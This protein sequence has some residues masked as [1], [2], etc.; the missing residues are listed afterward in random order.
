MPEGDE[1]MQFIT[2]LGLGFLLGARH[3]L[4]PDHVAAV[5][6]IVSERPD[7][8]ASG[9]VG[10]CWGFGHTVILLLVGVAII[11]L[12]ITIPE[13]VAQALELGV[14]LMLIALGGSLAVTLIRERWHLHPHRHASGTHLHL[15]THRSGQDHLHGHSLLRRRSVKPFL[16]GMVHGLAGSAALTLMLLSTVRTLWEGVL[17]ILVFGFGSILGMMVLGV[18]ISIP[19]VLSASYLPRARVA[20][21]GLAS[22]GSMG[23][24]LIMLY[25]I[26]L[27]DS[28]F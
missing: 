14:G 5:S 16:V 27:G 23:L 28:P 1:E 10:A 11:L 20:L 2:L 12:K 7:L 21:Q 3:A 22:V 6:A 25:R 8:R 17:Y 18:L 24:G 9:F 15:H 13:H 4:D 26:S 19:L